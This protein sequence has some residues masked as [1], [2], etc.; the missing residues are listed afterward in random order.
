MKVI[1]NPTFL[2][3][4]W[5]RRSG[6]IWRFGENHT[7]RVK[8]SYVRREGVGTVCKSTQSMTSSLAIRKNTPS[9]TGGIQVEYLGRNACPIA[10]DTSLLHEKIPL[11]HDRTFHG[12]VCLFRPAISDSSSQCHSNSSSIAPRPATPYPDFFKYYLRFIP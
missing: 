11:R 2:E 8:R 6:L 10:G 1:C 3:T 5:R 4:M 9:T 12:S 7:E